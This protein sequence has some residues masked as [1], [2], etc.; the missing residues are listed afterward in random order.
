MNTYTNDDP[1]H[2]ATRFDPAKPL[3]VAE[4]LD[5]R[6]LGVGQLLCPLDLLEQRMAGG[7][8]R[9]RFAAQHHPART[10]EHEEGALGEGELANTGPGLLDGATQ[11]L[12]VGARVVVEQLGDVLGAGRH[13]VAHLFAVALDQ[14][15]QPVDGRPDLLGGDLVLVD[16]GRGDAGQQQPARREQQQLAPGNRRVE[17][18]RWEA[19]RVHGRVFVDRGCHS[20]L[21]ATNTS[22]T[23]SLRAR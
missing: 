18:G 17:S 9:V 11:A 3:H 19:W 16:T 8:I 7:Q 13:A 6:R 14:R 5:Q 1:L 23:R 15:L 10:D 12:R 4:G 21:R 2:V 20:G 22:S